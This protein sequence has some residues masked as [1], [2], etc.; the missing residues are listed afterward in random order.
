M[1]ANE[2]LVLEMLALLKAHGVRDVVISPGSRHYAFTRSFEA[3]DFFRLHSVVD[4]RSAGFFAIGLTQASGEPAAMMC[5]SGSA[6]VNYASAMAEA[7]YQRRPLIAITSDRLPE[8]LGQVEDQMIDQRG[9]YDGFVRFSGQLRPIRDARDRWF[10]NRVINE[11]LLEAT[12]AGSGPVHLNVPIGSHSGGT[13]DVPALPRVRVIARHG[14]AAARIDWQAVVD[15]LAGKRILVAWGQ[16]DPPDSG[17]GDALAEFAATFGAVVIADHLAN[18]RG[19]HR[20]RNP[21]GLLR[22]LGPAKGKIS[23]DIVIGGGGQMLFK[24][25]LA[26]LI[27]ASGFEYWR[28]DPKGEVADPFRT[29]TDIFSTTPADFFQGVVASASSTIGPSPY[30][31]RLRALVEKL[32]LPDSRHGEMSTIGSLLRRVP[33]GSSVQ[34]ANSAPVRMAE[35]FPL[36]PSIDVFCN[37]GVNG[38]DGCLSTAIGYAKACDVP[39]FVIIGDLAFFYDMN[40]LTIRDLPAGLRILLVNNGGGAVMHAPLPYD[41]T[42][43]GGRHVSAEHS[44]DARGWIESLGVEY[45][46]L[47]PG[48]DTGR[49]VAWL[50]DLGHRG[51]RVLEAFSDKIDDIEQLRGF[52]ATLAMGTG[53]AGVYRRL[54][55]FAGRILRRLGLR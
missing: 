40:A 55:R 21:L 16:D 36:D 29:L 43:H 44:I 1:Y 28:I 20:L 38:I 35:M 26:R 27:G 23:P 11:A 19:D 25:D 3:D 49:A 9:I 22:A 54:R 48:G 2:P 34:I 24:D 31:A 6:A 47:D 8:N 39:T 14:E 42:R 52:N 4:E 51:P 10:C 50:S 15:R 41:Y 37:R 13:F 5:T 18:I 17:T 12:R 46:R 45:D 53:S 7:Y 32:P 30:G 33:A